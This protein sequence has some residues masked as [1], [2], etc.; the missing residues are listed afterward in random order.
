[1]LKI[2]ISSILLM[3]FQFSYAANSP[4]SYGY[5]KD[6]KQ[7]YAKIG[8]DKKT[9]YFEENYTGNPIVMFSFFNGNPSIVLSGRSVNDYTAYATLNYINDTFSIDCIY[10]DMKSKENGISSKNGICGLGKKITDEYQDVIEGFVEDKGN[11]INNID[12]SYVINGGTKKLPIL[13]FRNNDNFLYQLYKNKNDFLNDKYSILSISNKTTCQSYEGTVWVVEN[14]SNK[15]LPRV[16]N[17]ITKNGVVFL[18]DAIT[19]SHRPS[20]EGSCQKFQMFSVK[21]EKSFF[22]NENNEIKKPYLVHGDFVNLLNMS[23]GEKWCDISYL[24][25]ANKKVNGRVLC[26]TLKL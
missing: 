18:E 7:I 15:V 26:A 22:Y 3:V 16:L 17:E 25:K 21:S 10:I 19:N 14:F 2:I 20:E 4:V 24:N 13:I 6:H 12:T 1:M 8:S 5:D 9:L 11:R 23:E